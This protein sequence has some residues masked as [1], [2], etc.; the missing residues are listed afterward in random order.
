[1]AG[2]RDDWFVLA[3]SREL[4]PLRPTAATTWHP[5]FLM[6]PPKYSFLLKITFTRPITM[7]GNYSDVNLY[8]DFA[9]FAVAS[10]LI[11]MASNAFVYYWVHFGS[12]K[13]IDNRF[14][15]VMTLQLQSA[16]RRRL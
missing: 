13:T 6:F 4:L 15:R 3:G 7:S 11:K 14:I 10:L 5:L 8:V 2:R 9:G 16:E 12:D 1:M